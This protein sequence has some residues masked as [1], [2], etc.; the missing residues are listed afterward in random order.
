M[1]ELVRQ[2]KQRGE[3]NLNNIGVSL[4]RKS[5]NKHLREHKSEETLYF[6]GIKRVH[7]SKYMIN[8]CNVI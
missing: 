6:K 4:E 5:V 8:G 1:V 7:K 3:H 2:L